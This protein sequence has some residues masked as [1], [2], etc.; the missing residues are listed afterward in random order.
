MLCVCMMCMLCV[1][2]GCACCVCVCRM[3]MLCVYVGCACCVCVCRMCMLCVYVGCACCVC[4]Y[5]LI[6]VR[7]LL[8]SCYDVICPRCFS[9]GGK[10]H[11]KAMCSWIT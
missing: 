9:L 2:V 4:M 1:Y 7:C 5:V 8:S 11:F 10:L 3:C 6:F